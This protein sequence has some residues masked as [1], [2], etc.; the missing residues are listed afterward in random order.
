[1]EDMWK[2]RKRPVPLDFDE[3][4][5]A[6]SS[7]ETTNCA[8]GIKDQRIL[9]TKDSFDLFVDSLSRLATRAQQA[10]NSPMEWDKDD[11]DALDFATSAA[12]LRASVFSIP[13]KTRFDVKQM[14]GNIIPAIATTNAIIAGAIIMQALHAL[15]KNWSKARSVWFGRTAQRA[16]NSTSLEKP[17]PG[18]PTCRT[19]YVSLKVDAEK[20]T[21]ETL[22]EDVVKGWLGVE[23]DISVVEG[24]RIIY[25]PDFEDNLGKTL[26]DLNIKHGSQLQIN[27]EEGSKIPVIFMLSE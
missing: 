24:S 17:N 27:D 18:C 15:K 10:P 4:Q 7:S 16:L 26:G 2:H 8:G 21:L 25:D 19:P 9:S 23:W 22:V 5:S 11:D 6:A 13:S 12:N 1:M 3:L 20:M 14:A